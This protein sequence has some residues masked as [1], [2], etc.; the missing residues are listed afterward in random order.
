MKVNVVKEQMYSLCDQ[1]AVEEYTEV[2]AIIHIDTN[3]PIRTQRNL[4]IHAAIEIFCPSWVHE[5]VEELEELIID[6]IDKVEE[7]KC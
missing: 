3:M 6:V 7:D 4:A 1:E 5:K 2:N